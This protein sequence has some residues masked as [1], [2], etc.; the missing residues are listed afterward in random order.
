MIII[1]KLPTTINSTHTDWFYS[2]HSIFLSLPIY[3]VVL[4]CTFS[5]DGLSIWGDENNI[6]AVMLAVTTQIRMYSVSTVCLTSWLELCTLAAEIEC[7]LCVI[8]RL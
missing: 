6:C 7:V 5:S 8:A 4:F 1:A 3:P 2:V